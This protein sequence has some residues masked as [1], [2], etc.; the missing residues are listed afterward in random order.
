MGREHDAVV[1]LP[2]R[3][4]GIADDAAGG[5]EHFLADDAEIQSVE[6]D[7]A[8]NHQCAV[9][10]CFNEMKDVDGVIFVG[11]VLEDRRF[12]TGIGPGR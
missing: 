2:F 10:A 5:V 6:P 12:G 9:G 11:G 8:R 7:I 1:H 3:I 4:P